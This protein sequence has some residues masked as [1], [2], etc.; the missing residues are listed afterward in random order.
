VEGHGQSESG[1]KEKNIGVS[2]DM[3]ANGDQIRNISCGQF[4]GSVFIC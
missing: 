2:E 3:I 4:Y 1:M